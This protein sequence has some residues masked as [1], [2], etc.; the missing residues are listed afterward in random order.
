MKFLVYNFSLIA[1]LV[2]MFTFLAIFLILVLS[3]LGSGLSINMVACTMPLLSWLLAFIGLT[4]LWFE[5]HF[6]NLLNQSNQVNQ[7]LAFKSFDYYFWILISPHSGKLV[8]TIYYLLFNIFLFLL[9]AWYFNLMICSIY[10]I[11]YK[12]SLRICYYFL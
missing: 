12:L 10:S 4:S 3:Q 8:S 5:A 1:S 2:I 7:C 9:F 11:T 6:L